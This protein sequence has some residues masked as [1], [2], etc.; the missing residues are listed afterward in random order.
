MATTTL[1]LFPSASLKN[2]SAGQKGAL[3][4]VSRSVKEPDFEMVKMSGNA[5]GIVI[6]VEETPAQLSSTST[7]NHHR[8]PDRI[9]GQAAVPSAT[10]SNPPQVR[11]ADRSNRAP[12][13]APIVTQVRT[14]VEQRLRSASSPAVRL[15]ESPT[16][17]RAPSPLQGDES[18]QSRASSPT[19]VRKGSGASTRTATHSPMMRSMFPRYDPNMTLAQQRYQPHAQAKRTPPVAPGVAHSPSLYSQQSRRARRLT[20]PVLDIPQTSSRSAPVLQQ[21]SQAPSSS[22]LSTPA[23][24][25]QLWSI[26]NGQAVPDAAE[27]YCLELSW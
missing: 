15:A 26:A 9:C 6:A 19:L 16:R 27:T 18:P 8:M 20:L 10:L 14:P 17:S 21:V 12:T 11:V 24:L 3:R 1:S 5:H 2:G 7:S 25:P 22:A 4:Y 13:P 23:Q